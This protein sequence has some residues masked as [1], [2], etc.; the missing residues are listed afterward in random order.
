MDNEIFT[1]QCAAM[2]PEK[3]KIAA[4]GINFMGYALYTTGYSILR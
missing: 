3:V 4:R 1:K 2:P